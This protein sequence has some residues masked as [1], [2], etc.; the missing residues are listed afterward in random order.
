MWF[1]HVIGAPSSSIGRVD[2]VLLID[3]TFRSA[4]A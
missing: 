1:Y 2:W 4:D 3:R